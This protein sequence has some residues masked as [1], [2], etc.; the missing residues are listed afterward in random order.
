M[1][2]WKWLCKVLRAV[3]GHGASMAGPSFLRLAC[4]WFLAP[5]I[6]RFMSQQSPPLRAADRSCVFHWRWRSWR[7]S[8]FMLICLLLCS[9]GSPAWAG[10]TFAPER[11]R[12][13]GAFEIWRL[14][15]GERMGML[16]GGFLYDM[17]K[18]FALGPAAWGA[19]TGQRGGFITLGLA[20]DYRLDIG[21]WQLNAGAFVGAGGGRG[22]YQLQGGGLMLREH[23]GIGYRLWPSLTLGAGVSRVDFPNGSIHST[24]PYASLSLP[25]SAALL[26]ADANWPGGE[27]DAWFSMPSTEQELSLVYRFERIPAGVR[28]DAG[29]PQHSTLG[30]VGVAWHR[31]FGD[32]LFLNLDS[33]GAMQGN[34][35]GYMQILAGLGWRSRLLRGTWLKAIVAAGPAG[36]GA[37]ATGG[38]VLLDAR[39]GVQ[40][41]LWGRTFAELE[42]GKSRALNGDFRATTYSLMFGGHFDTPRVGD[43]TF[44]D[45]DL[46]GYSPLHL[47]LRW[48]GQRYLQA[49]SGWRNHHA[50]LSVDVMGWQLDAFVTPHWYLT[51]QGLGAWR[52]QG[53][54]YMTGLVGA[55]AHL[56]LGG[57]PVFVEG[58][59]LVGAAGGGGLDVAGGLVWQATAM[60]GASLTKGFEVLTGYGVM[61]APKGRFRARVWSLSL[62]KRLTLPVR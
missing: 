10:Q 6:E 50:N 30:L 51:G 22:G 21:R 12:L 28:T 5:G 54:G 36:G 39:A 56:P 25:F 16:G 37:V 13:T 3:V 2:G 32:H 17:G 1:G 41:R 19:V 59:A 27:G 7:V 46:A 49:A 14:P 60:V 23:L 4:V 20:G 40:Q 43:R 15:A 61:R 48:T 52:G 45:S 35:H 58:E 38:G 11:A 26:P 55:G 33:E 62:A 47:R 34:S 53:G 31:Y 24:Q 57:T 44:R 8:V 42:I 29:A 18:G 9:P